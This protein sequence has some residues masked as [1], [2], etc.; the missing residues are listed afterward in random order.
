MDNGV[1]LAILPIIV[2]FV[3]VLV[4]IAVWQASKRKTRVDYSLAIQNAWNQYNLAVLD[5]EENLKIADWLSTYNSEKLNESNPV[6]CK[7]I[8]YL[9]LNAINLAFLANKEGVGDRD[10]ITQNIN[11]LLPP[12]LLKDEVFQLT[13]NKGYSLSFAKKCRELRE[14]PSP[15]TL[16]N[17]SDY[18]VKFIAPLDTNK[19]TLSE[20]KKTTQSLSKKKEIKN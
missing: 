17:I 10:Y 16:K 6:R 18:K 20:S 7:Y 9:K 19:K 2:S 15:E 3:G 12:M 14:K 13:Q 1:Y 5:C 4:S 11:Q 8:A